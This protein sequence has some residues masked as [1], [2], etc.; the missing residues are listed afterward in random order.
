[1]AA[2]ESWPADAVAVARRFADWG[3][4]R[5]AVWVME[6]DGERPSRY[7]VVAILDRLLDDSVRGERLD[8]VLE[9]HQDESW[10]ITQARASRRCWPDRGHESFGTDP[11]R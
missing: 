2:G 9:L 6:G 1:V 4:E 7:T 5:T 11:C 10:R 8:L 3:V